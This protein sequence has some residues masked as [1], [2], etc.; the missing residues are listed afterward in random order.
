MQMDSR[1]FEDMAKLMSG[2]MGTMAGLREEMEA[3]MRQQLERFF[4]RLDMVTR[5]EFEAVQE[6]AANARAEQEAMAER[7]AELEAKLAKMEK[8]GATASTRRSGTSRH[9][10]PPADNP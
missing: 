2:A 8:A 7:L 1:L 4:S 9:K 5:E 10:S 3:Q 6:M